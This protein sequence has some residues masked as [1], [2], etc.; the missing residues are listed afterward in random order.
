MKSQSLRQ[1][2]IM[3]LLW[4]MCIP[5]ALAQT[6]LKVH[7][8]VTDNQNEPLIGVSVREKGTNN[9]SISDLDGNYT[10]SVSK[11]STLVFTYVGYTSQEQKVTSSTLNVTLLENKKVL[12]EVV[13]VGYGVQKKSSGQVPSPKFVLRTCRT[14]PS[15]MP[16]RLC[17]VRRPVFRSSPQ[18]LQV[19]LLPSVFVVIPLTAPLIHYMLSMV[20][21]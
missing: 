4:T 14:A 3:V 17:R 12:E 6:M 5:L 7:G 13:I 15:A 16:S 18:L 1:I 19:V 11:G 8:T 2:A 20:C 21:A 10:L 9:A